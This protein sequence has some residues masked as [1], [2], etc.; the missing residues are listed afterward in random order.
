MLHP[1]IFWGPSAGLD[2]SISDWSNKAWRTV[3][4]FDGNSKIEVEYKNCDSE[5]YSFVK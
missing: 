1:D 2:K 4:T 3:T 5:G